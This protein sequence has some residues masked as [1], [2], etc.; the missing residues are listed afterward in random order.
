ML[1]VEA[2]LPGRPRGGSEERS[3]A[4]QMGLE[5]R[6]K[7]ERAPGSWVPL[8]APPERRQRSGGLCPDPSGHGGGGGR[9]VRPQRATRVGLHA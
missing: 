8:D 1:P 6:T 2:S 3:P 7:E 4:S 9:Y 5:E